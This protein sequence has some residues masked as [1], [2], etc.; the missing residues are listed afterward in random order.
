MAKFGFWRYSMATKKISE[1]AAATT[2]LVGDELVEIVQGGANV[3]V[4]VSEFG[5][6]AGYAAVETISAT[7]TDLLASHSGKYLRFTGV[8]AKTLTVQNDATEPLSAD[9]EFHIRNVGAGDLTLVEDTA[10]TI[11]P[12]NGGTLDVPTGG[13]VTLKRVAEDEF[14]LLGQTVAA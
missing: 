13:T 10:V 3:K 5:G 4:P 11:N 8:V 7:D 6:G 12:P 9:V 14:D 2:P 1:L